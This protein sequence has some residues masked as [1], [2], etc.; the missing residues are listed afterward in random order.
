ME[1]ERTTVTRLGAL[2][3]LA[4]EG[5]PFT[6]PKPLLLLTYLAFEGSQL[7]RHLAELFWQ[8]GNRM[9]SLSMA[10]TLLRKGASD[11]VEV[12]VKQVKSLVQSDVKELLDALDK[13]NWEQATHLYT[14]AF[15][16]GSYSRSGFTRHVSI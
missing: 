11:V 5:S 6:R 15:C 13:S 4:L 3:G 2:G 1:I 8:E 16:K 14:G 7:R 12:D 10:L 9:K